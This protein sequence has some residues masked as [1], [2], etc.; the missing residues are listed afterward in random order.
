MKTTELQQ[1]AFR[2][3]VYGR[4]C[5]ALESGIFFA[6]TG[7]LMVKILLI[8]GAI[9]FPKQEDGYFMTIFGIAIGFIVGAMFG[10]GAGISFLIKYISPPKK[11]IKK[12]IKI[13]SEEIERSL[14]NKK[15]QIKKLEEEHSELI[16]EESRL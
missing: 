3:N 11:V 12:Y 4:M 9:T 7:Y 10:G 8:T 16:K 15:E 14:K 2:Y 6:S 5:C 13:R 1:N